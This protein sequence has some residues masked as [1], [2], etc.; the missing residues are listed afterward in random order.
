MTAREIIDAINGEENR[1]SK[2]SVAVQV[3]FL[4]Q[5]GEA[6][7]DGS[8]YATIKS[9]IRITRVRD[10]V[11]LDLQFR[12][13]M[14]RDIDI[15]WNIINSYHEMLRKYNKETDEL[16]PYL[17]FTIVPNKYEGRYFAVASEPIFWSLSSDHAASSPSCIHLCFE[18][19]TF[20]IYEADVDTR[21]LNMEI[22]REMGITDEYF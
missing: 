18:A 6:V 12:T 2:A 3:S 15:I 13:N 19:E 1:I 21:R 22:K 11:Q 17:T 9:I 16:Y 7:K 10:F 20:M 4:N 5:K 14:E 8:S